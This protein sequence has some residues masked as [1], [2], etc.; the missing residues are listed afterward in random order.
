VI[1]PHAGDF[2]VF[3][4]RKDF[5]RFVALVARYPNVVMDNSALA[6]V[7]R[8]RR[9]LRLLERT[10]LTDR[11]LHGSDFPLPSHAWAFALRIGWKKARALQRIPS[12]LEKDVLLKRELGVP[13]PVFTQASRI[14]LLRDSR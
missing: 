1:V 7:H 11:V 4:D 3:G 12:L 9:L 2:R 5:E 10:D 14:L 8:R 13:D 6:L